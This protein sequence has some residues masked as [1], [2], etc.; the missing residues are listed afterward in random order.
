MGVPRHV[1]NSTENRTPLSYDNAHIQKIPTK[2]DVTA[3][4]SVAPTFT[5]PTLHYFNRTHERTNSY[6]DRDRAVI[7]KRF[8]DLFNDTN[9][10]NGDFP[11]LSST[12]LTNDY[13]SLLQIPLPTKIKVVMMKTPTWKYCLSAPTIVCCI[14]V[15]LKIISCYYRV[16]RIVNNSRRQ[17]SDEERRPSVFDTDPQ[18]TNETGPP[19]NPPPVPTP[20]SPIIIDPEFSTQ[21]NSHSDLPPLYSQCAVG[22]GNKIVDNTSEDLPPPYST[23]IDTLNAT[24]DIPKVRKGQSVEEQSC[25]ETDIHLNNLHTTHRNNLEQLD[26]NT[27]P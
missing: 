21:N 25:T 23:C 24:N 1:P 8:Q 27:R 4:P 18:Q 12:N 17:S 5:F 6:S 20:T 15:V 13:S 11:W 3:R 16:Q 10:L 22:G 19:P 2:E 26:S 9:F 14:L 7:H